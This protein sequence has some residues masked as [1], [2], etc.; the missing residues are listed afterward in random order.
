[1]PDFIDKQNVLRILEENGGTNAQLS[2]IRDLSPVRLY[3]DGYAF[4]K[5]EE[6][7]NAVLATFSF[8]AQDKRKP[9]KTISLFLEFDDEQ[10]SRYLQMGDPEQKIKFIKDTLFQYALR[11]VKTFM[12]LKKYESHNYVYRFFDYLSETKFQFQSP[13]TA[14]CPSAETVTVKM[15]LD[16]VLLSRHIPIEVHVE[17]NSFD[18]LLRLE[19]NNKGKLCYL[20]GNSELLTDDIFRSSICTNSCRL[21]LP[22]ETCF[23]ISGTGILGARASGVMPAPAGRGVLLPV[24]IQ[25]LGNTGEPVDTLSIFLHLSPSEHHNYRR[26]KSQKPRKKLFLRLLRR[27]ALDEIWKSRSYPAYW[28]NGF[29]HTVHSFLSANMSRY[30]RPTQGFTV[31]QEELSIKM[32]IEE[33]LVSGYIP[34]KAVVQET[35]FA[36]MMVLDESGTAKLYD[37]DTLEPLDINSKVS[38]TGITPDSISHNISLDPY[39]DF[40][41]KNL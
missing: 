17:E 20:N 21:S 29:S 5:K 38:I 3:W 8:Y 24:N 36:A 14:F 41:Y 12:G 19:G 31:C 2:L 23:E 39:P 1:M 27:E 22:R 28:K 11:T 9:A 6:L 37:S 40:S 18:A 13:E 35:N 4:Q 16:E 7:R 30:G 32:P 25:F 10:Y 34:L 26:I 15:P 33:P